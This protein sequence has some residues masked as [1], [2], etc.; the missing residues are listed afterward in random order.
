MTKEP[1]T[2]PTWVVAA[3]RRRH[4]GILILNGWRVRGPVEEYIMN[5]DRGAVLVRKVPLGDPSVHLAPLPGGGLSVVCTVC[6]E[7]MRFASDDDLPRTAYCSNCGTPHELHP[8]GGFARQGEPQ[9][10]VGM[11]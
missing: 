6:D 5:T 8:G 9:A 7:R 4:P 2:L 10:V 1:V 3:A 11:E